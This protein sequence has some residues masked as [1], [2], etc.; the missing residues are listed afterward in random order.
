M[1]TITI[2]ETLEAIQLAKAVEAGEKSIDEIAE[3][4]EPRNIHKKIN[5]ITKVITQALKDFSGEEKLEQLFADAKNPQTLEL[6]I[7]RAKHPY[8]S[9]LILHD[10][11]QT[12]L[13][14]DQEK[15][16]Y[17]DIFPG[18]VATDAPRLVNEEVEVSLDYA[19]LS[20]LR[21]LVAP[22]NWLSTGLYAPAG[23]NIK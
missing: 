19:D 22:G 8:T 11:Q 14:P 7:D 17:A 3:S 21:M 2:D 18:P 23:E 4:S 6:P 16:P 9:A 15:S 12:T 13:A 1:E 10:C 20:Y 5:D